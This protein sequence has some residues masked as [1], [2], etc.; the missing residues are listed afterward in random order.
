MEDN[1]GRVGFEVFFSV[2]LNIFVTSVALFVDIVVTFRLIVDFIDGNEEE[3]VVPSDGFV[4]GIKVT[5]IFFL[6]TLIVGLAVVSAT[7]CPVTDVGFSFTT[8]LVA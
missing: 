3:V 1:G 7:V 8:F 6:V 5:M 4:V 2:V